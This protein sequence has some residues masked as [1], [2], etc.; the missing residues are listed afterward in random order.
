MSYIES[1]NIKVFPTTQRDQTNYPESK[2]MSES[3]IVNLSNRLTENQS[4]VISGLNYDGIT[5]SPGECVINGYYFKINNNIT[6]TPG[7]NNFLYLKIKIDDNQL[8]GGDVN[9]EYR[10][11]SVELL[12]YEPFDGKDLTGTMWRLDSTIDTPT[13]EIGYLINFVSNSNNYEF[14]YLT[15]ASGASGLFYTTY[16]ASII[17]LAYDSETEQWTNQGYKTIIIKNGNDTTNNNLI[18]WLENNGDTSLRTEEGTYYLKI[19]EKNNGV[20]INNINSRLI[21]NGVFYIDDG[22]I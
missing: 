1:N 15:N 6:L 13:S 14:F 11:L 10:G 4:Y 3:N 5:L 19:S 8:D 9:N 22:V 17:D 21:K 7:N 2:L 18:S 16:D 20:W 12:P